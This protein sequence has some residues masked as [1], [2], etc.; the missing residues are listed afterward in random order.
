MVVGDGDVL[1]REGE[2]QG[3][4][5]SRRR[6][7]RKRSETLKRVVGDAYALASGPHSGAIV[8][9]DRAVGRVFQTNS[10][11][12]KISLWKLFQAIGAA[13]LY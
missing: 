3:R 11:Q 10:K 2:Q 7:E 1:G 4:I 12:I 6:P 9:V 13:I 8:E 5:K